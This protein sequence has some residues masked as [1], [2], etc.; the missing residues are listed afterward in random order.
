[1]SGH[2]FDE[3]ATRGQPIKFTLGQHNMIEGW[4]LGLL[5]MCIGD[6]RNLTVPPSMAYGEEAWGGIPGNSVLRF[7]TRLVAI[8]GVEP[9]TDVA[10]IAPAAPTAPVDEKTTSSPQKAGECRLLGPFA[11][12]VQAAL[13]LIALLSLVFKRWREQPRRP[14]QVWFFDAS[15][16]VVGT[17]LL[18]VLNLAMSMLS[19]QPRGVDVASKAQ[20]VAQR[21][22]DASAPPNP[23]SF[24][25]L[26]LAIDVR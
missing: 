4:E 13:G 18:H 15:K 16:Q 12:V 21:I 23:C 7:W 19:S 26:N 5:D 25:L 22:G 10:V 6:E 14:L 17:A 8:E 24:Y 9:D 2:V 11:L 1:M 3:S 20:I